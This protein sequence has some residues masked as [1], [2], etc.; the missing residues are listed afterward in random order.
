MIIGL[1]D[2]F[3]IYKGKKTI[4]LYAN[5]LS[6]LFIVINFQG[7]LPCVKELFSVQ[8][9]FPCKSYKIFRFHLFRIISWCTLVCIMIRLVV[10]LGMIT[11]FFLK[12]TRRFA[13]ECM[14]Y[15]LIIWI[16]AKFVKKFLLN[17]LNCYLLFSAYS[18]L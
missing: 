17:W 8:R 3:K 9:G 4:L 7:S 12:Q 15:D 14:I 1:I 11:L 6:L 5:L 2:I 16:E 10:V 18:S 13:T